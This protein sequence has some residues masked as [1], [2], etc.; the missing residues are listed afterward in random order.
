MIE[1][2]AIFMRV[3]MTDEPRML[4]PLSRELEMVQA[5]LQIEHVRLGDRLHVAYDLDDAASA[6]LVPSLL[7]QPLV[8]N[9]VKHAVAPSLTG[10]IITIRAHA[11]EGDLLLVVEDRLSSPRR[12]PPVPGTGVGLQNVAARLTAQFGDRATLSTDCHDDGFTATIRLP[13]QSAANDTWR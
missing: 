5:Y 2:L 4:V 13:A 1:R 10:A 8:E 11:R 3:T 9:A 6:M 7:L 12:F